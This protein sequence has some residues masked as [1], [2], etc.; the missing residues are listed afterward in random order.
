MA[1][2]LYHS[3]EDILQT[4]ENF[5][6]LRLACNGVKLVAE[7]KENIEWKIFTKR[8]RIGTH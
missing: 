2:C 3:Q 1:K 6:T 8:K 4:S 7:R 5:S